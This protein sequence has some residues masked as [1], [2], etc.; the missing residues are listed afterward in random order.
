[1]NEAAK[2][3][4]AQLGHV[5]R[6]EGLLLAALTH[7]SREKTD[8]KVSAYERL[9]FLGDR[10]LSLIIAEWLFTLFPE[11]NEGQ[12]AKRHAG[13]VNRDTLAAVAETLNIAEALQMVGAG[14]LTRGRVNILSDALEAII[15]SIWCDGGPAAF[16]TIREAIHRLWQ[17][18][19]NESA[20]AP[21]DAKSAL[22][23]W[24]QA[25]SLPLP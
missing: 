11:E 3:L 5:F 1:M 10:V 20:E 25:R 16:P 8:K 12:L 7:P 13:L 23:E 17:P 14:D 19:L 9:E 6:D 18:H 2:A 21:Q 15:G 24:A 4:Q 22:Q